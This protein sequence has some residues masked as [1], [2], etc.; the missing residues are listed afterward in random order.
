MHSGRTAGL[1]SRAQV[2]HWPYNPGMADSTKPEVRYARHHALPEI[3]TAGQA[4]LADSHALVIGMGGLGCAA[5]QYLAASGIGHLT[6]NDFDTVDVS[7]L[8]RQ[9]LYREDDVGKLKVEAAAEA[10]QHMSPDLLISAESQRLDEAALA[11]ATATADIVL[12]GSDNFGTR[13]AVNAACVATGTPLVSGAAIQWRGQL[14][15]IDPLEMA[16]PCYACLYA[17]DDETLEDCAGNGV[18][19][20]LVGIIGASMAL[21]ASKVLLGLHR[22]HLGRLL[23]YDGLANRWREHEVPA[24]PACHVCEREST[25]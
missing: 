10:L 20:A 11:A 19:S 15:V 5:A 9:V 22:A 7:N 25:D 17:E 1:Q 8:S 24:D 2:S 18:V 3:G 12:D 16:S 14:F 21:E 13:F 4:V 6:L 23:T